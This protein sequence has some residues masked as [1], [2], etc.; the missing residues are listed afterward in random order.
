VIEVLAAIA[1]SALTIGAMGVG[2]AL[3]RSQQSRDTVVRLTT[4]VENVAKRLDEIHVDMKADRQQTYS[5]FS[6]L[7]RRVTKL[8]AQQ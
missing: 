5:L 3:N 6:D 8:E 2:G 4:A 7:D 1:G